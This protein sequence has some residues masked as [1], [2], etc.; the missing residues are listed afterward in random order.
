MLSFLDQIT[1]NS[2]VVLVDAFRVTSIGVSDAE[3]GSKYMIV[4]P[5]T[6]GIMFF[7]ISIRFH[8]NCVVMIRHWKKKERQDTSF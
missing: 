4:N 5:A 8:K 1:F 6:F 3:A 7:L 2:T